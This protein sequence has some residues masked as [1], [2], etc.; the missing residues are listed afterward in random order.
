M[1]ALFYSESPQVT[2]ATNVFVRVPVVLQYD[3]TPLIEVIRVQSAGFTTRI[4]LFH[5]DGTDLAR[6]VGSRLYATSEGKKAGVQLL[7]R[8]GVTVCEISGKTAFELRR[9]NAAALKTYA[10]L[11]TPE[12]AFI[13]CADDPRIEGLLPNRQSPLQIGGCVMQGN[14]FAGCRIGVLVRSDGTIALGSN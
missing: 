13:K 9:E 11:F 1:S 14:Y 5:N 12:G 8:D 6:V 4:S 3:E 2:I 7:H 10:E